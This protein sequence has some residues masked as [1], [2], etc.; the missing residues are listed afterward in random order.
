[1][2]RTVKEI[3]EAE[4]KKITEDANEKRKRIRRLSTAFEYDYYSCGEAKVLPKCENFEEY[5]ELSAKLPT[6]NELESYDLGWDRERDDCVMIVHTVKY[7][8]LY[9]QNVRYRFQVG[10]VHRTLDKISEGKCKIIKKMT[11]PTESVE[12]TTLACSDD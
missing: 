3:K 12:Y 1:M 6:D 2:L 9:N 11:R 4:L 10:D 5:L 8:K 7:G